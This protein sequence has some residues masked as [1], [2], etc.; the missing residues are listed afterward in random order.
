MVNG[1][2]KSPSIAK[3]PDS[4]KIGKA[5]LSKR[6]D[7]HAGSKKEIHS[8]RYCLDWIE[9]FF[10]EGLGTDSRLSG[11]HTLFSSAVCSKNIPLAHFIEKHGAGVDL[12]C[13]QASRFL[14]LFLRLTG[15]RGE[16][17]TEDWINKVNPSWGESKY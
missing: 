16:A 15:L 13:E 14:M 17:Q 1:A 2:P 5:L 10:Q 12:P 3:E 6:A 11:R 7:S 8:F 9:L 4:L